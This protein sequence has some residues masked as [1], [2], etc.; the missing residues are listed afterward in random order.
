MPVKD[1]D[2]TNKG[3][4][5]GPSDGGKT[6]GKVNHGGNVSAGAY[7]KSNPIPVKMDATAKMGGGNS[8]GFKGGNTAG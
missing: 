4:K 5:L 2:D 6:G 1:M 3:R 7:H 8:G